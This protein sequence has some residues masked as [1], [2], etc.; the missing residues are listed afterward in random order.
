MNRYALYPGCNPQMAEPE[1]LKSSHAVAQKLGIELIQLDRVSCCGG[2]H[3]QDRNAFQS[4]LLNARNFTFAERMQL[5]LVTICNTCQYI[6]A[7]AHHTLTTDADTRKQINSRL[8]TEKLEFRG[9]SRPRNL[10][11]VLR[12][13]VGRAAIRQHVSRPLR[14]LRV[15][16]YSG[17]HLYSP[18]SVQASHTNGES[19]W[20]PAALEDLIRDLGGEPVAYHSRNQCCGFHS[21]LYNPRTSRTLVHQILDDARSN[22]AQV[23]ITP[24]PLCHAN[25]EAFAPNRSIPVLYYQQLMGLAFELPWKVLGLQHNMSV[26]KKELL[27][28]IP[29]VPEYLQG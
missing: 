15:A 2:A 25:L 14:G 24:C 9:T 13:D 8:E 21:S 11:Y 3:L 19:P 6:L 4:L 16:A 1:L 20:N 23:L 12:E 27:N 18:S 26:R 5:D 22:D 28:L 29:A 10:L 7:E 17:C